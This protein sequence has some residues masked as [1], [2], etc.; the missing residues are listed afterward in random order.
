MLTPGFQT[1]SLQKYTSVIQASQYVVLHYN[2]P[3]KLSQYRL[4]F[5]PHG[6]LESWDDGGSEVG[7]A[8][9]PK[10]CLCPD[11][12]AGVPLSLPVGVHAY[13]SRKFH[14]Q[15]WCLVCSLTF[16]RPKD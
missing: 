15:A 11:S 12:W 5:A 1:P 13:S 4:R 6:A 3:N 16:L 14:T 9:F 8:G 10:G 7:P 2:N